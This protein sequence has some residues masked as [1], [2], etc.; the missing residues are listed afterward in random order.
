MVDG[1]A[2]LYCK[3]EGSNSRYFIQK[4]D[5]AIIELIEKDDEYIDALKF[6]FSDC[7]RIFHEINSTPLK[8]EPLMYL[9]RK[10][11]RF[12]SSEKNVFIVKPPMVKVL[13]GPFVSA[14]K[15]FMNY[16][17]SILYEAFDFKSW[18]Y[19][20]AGLVINT[21]FPRLMRI[22]SFQVSGE[23][24]R[25]HFYANAY[26]PYSS[27]IFEEVN[28]HMLT[29]KS[30]AG[31]KF[32]YPKGKFR[33]S[34]MIGASMVNTLNKDCRRLEDSFQDP[35]IF[36]NVGKENVSANNI[37]GYAFDLGFDYH[38]SS[39]FISFFSIGST[40]DTGGNYGPETYLFKY[41]SDRSL[42]TNNITLNINAG[43]Y[44]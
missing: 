7:P 15:S 32:T 6:S 35:V 40:I 20:S 43:F 33:P 21:S 8:Y 30:K 12:V 39:K 17:N 25:S 24:G 13:V 3:K 38:H 26:N 1:L 34:L 23:V 27:K 28:L 18:I 19:P 10:Y 31:F 29:F 36:I 22:L 11:N 37:Y 2:D 5:G 41:D 14:N 44:F 42:I 4:P 9:T 16:E